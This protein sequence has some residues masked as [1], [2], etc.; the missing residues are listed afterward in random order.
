MY[1]ISFSLNPKSRWGGQ[2][3]KLLA[4]WMLITVAHDVLPGPRTFRKS[5]WLVPTD[6]AWDRNHLVVFSFFI[7]LCFGFT[8]TGSPRERTSASTDEASLSRLSTAGKWGGDYKSSQH[9]AQIWW[10]NWA[11]SSDSTKYAF[12]K[13]IY[14]G[15]EVLTKET[16]P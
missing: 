4:V 9:N 1:S 13:C 7:F 8:V 12:K 16:E 14:K 2:I 5:K 15:M 10:S 11:P 3:E 6:R